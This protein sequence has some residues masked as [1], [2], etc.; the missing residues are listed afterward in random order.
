MTSLQTK[1]TIMLGI[2]DHGNVFAYLRE[3]LL[4]PIRWEHM[5]MFV[6]TESLLVNH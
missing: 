1:N 2:S 5:L 3:W 6:V 4:L